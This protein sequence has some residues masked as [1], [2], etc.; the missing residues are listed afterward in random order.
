MLALQKSRRTY[1][2]KRKRAALSDGPPRNLSTCVEKNYFFSVVAGAAG[3]AG[4]VVVAA[5][6]AGGVA[7]AAGSAG[8]VVVASGAGA[9]SVVAAGAASSV[10]VACG[11]QAATPNARTAATAAAKPSFIFVIGLYPSSRRDSVVAAAGK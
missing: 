8:G 6:S 5:A 4:A 11:P 9:A 1:V 10:F 3:A 2:K 7:V